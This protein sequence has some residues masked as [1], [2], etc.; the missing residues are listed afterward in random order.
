MKNS[1]RLVVAASVF[2]ASCSYDLGSLQGGLLDSGS[3]DSG[4]L[5][6]GSGDVGVPDA[7][8]TQPDTLVGGTSGGGL[9]GSGGRGDA[10]VPDAL[11]THPDVPIGGSGGSSGTSGVGGM[12]SSTGGSGGSAGA[13]G[14]GGSTCGLVGCVHPTDAGHTQGNLKNCGNGVLDNGETCDD[15]VPW[16]KKLDPVNPFDDGC[17]ALCQIEADYLCPEPNQPCV[18]Q[19]VCGNGVVTVDENCDDKNTVSGDGCSADCQTIEPG[20]ECRVP[21]KPCTPI[22][23]DS[24]LTGSE[25]CD[26]GNTTDGDGCSSTCQIEPGSTCPTPPATGACTKAVCGNGVKEKNEQCDCGTDPTKLPSGVATGLSGSLF[27]RD[28]RDPGTSLA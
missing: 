11:G 12:T 27:Q 22:C 3:G 19:R 13:S 9:G 4:G 17:N 18:S 1:A 20:W 28:H 6:G 2:A 5:G 26:D 25:T 10:G 7:P 24:K 8:A 21:G 23:G 14:A 16:A 15:G